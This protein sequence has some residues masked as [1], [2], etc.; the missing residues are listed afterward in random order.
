MYTVDVVTAD[1][2]SEKRPWDN[3]VQQLQ[4]LRNNATNLGRLNTTECI[5]RYVN[6][7]AGLTD[8]ILVASNV[9]MHDHL[10]FALDKSSSLL[11]YLTFPSGT[12]WSFA[13][14]WMCSALN[15]PN[16]LCTKDVIFPNAEHW[17]YFD[18]NWQGDF[19]VEVDY[20]IPAEDLHPMDG[21]CALRVSPIILTMI[22]V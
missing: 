3:A 1:F 4:S 20:C 6:R 21:K 10:S 8:M 16:T 13:S 15:R 5:N 19:R 18:Q 9:T 22:C 12:A 11:T 14:G 17:T 7:S 2:L